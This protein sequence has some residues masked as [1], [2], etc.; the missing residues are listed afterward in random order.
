VK[1][2]LLVPFQVLGVF[3]FFKTVSSHTPSLVYMAVTDEKVISEL[4]ASSLFYALSAAGVGL[5]LMFSGRILKLT[6]L[7]MGGSKYLVYSASAALIAAVNIGRALFD[8]SF[9]M[10]AALDGQGAVNQTFL[11][12]KY[13]SIS[14]IIM[15][16]LYLAWKD[17]KD[18]HEFEEEV[19]SEQPDQEGQC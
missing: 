10:S 8:G 6:S 4:F 16:L 5:L 1:N 12:V 11:A 13:S 2:N 17:L 19:I 15:I 9:I 7:K 14:S 3:I 18:P